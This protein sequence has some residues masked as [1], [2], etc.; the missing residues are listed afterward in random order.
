MRDEYILREAD[1]AVNP[2]MRNMG[3]GLPK[4]RERLSDFFVRKYGEIAFNLNLLI[5]ERVGNAGKRRE[6]VV[7]RAPK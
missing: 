3:A 7:A 5:F 2:E 1:R 4:R 6:R